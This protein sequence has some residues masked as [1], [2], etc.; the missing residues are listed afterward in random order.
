MTRRII[1]NIPVLLMMLL[2]SGCISV[3]QNQ[4]PE[5]AKQEN[6]KIQSWSQLD[7]APGVTTTI[8][9]DLI[10]SQELSNLVTEA[11]SANPGLQQTLLTLKMRQLELKQSQGAKQPTIEAGASVGKEQDSDTSYSGSLGISWEL[12]LWRKLSDES[13]AAAKDVA[14]QQA[15]YQAARDT[16][17]SEVMKAWLELIETEKSINIQKQRIAVLDQNTSLI[18]DRY[19]NGLGELSD[20]DSAR[21]SIAS[22]KATLAEYQQEQS[23]LQR[24]LATLLGQSTP[25]TIESAQDYPAVLLPLVDLPEQ[26]LQRRPDLKAAYLAIEAA[27]LRTSVAY[28]EML[29]SI[30]LQ[31][32]L[33]DVATSPSALLLQDSLW[34]LLGQLTAPL[35]QGGQLKTAAQI[36]ELETEQ[37]YQ[38]YRETLLTA[39][40]EVEDAIALE[41]SLL[42]RQQ[43]IEQALASARN[44]FTQYQHSYRNGLV[45]LLDLLTVQEQTYDLEEQLNTI[46]YNRL[47]NRIDLGL[48]LGLGVKS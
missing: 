28:K 29:P 26:T 2:L 16:L 23:S 15:T 46:I 48:A 35:Y 34:S 22:A 39:V 24:S 43:Y 9:G 10:R 40:N 42:Q 37:A 41:K 31:A 1:D 5:Q 33:E 44:T 11:L 20:L 14:E 32:A 7:T 8:L 17:A 47:A 38:A 45:E 36:A 13:Q 19:R 3:N 18:T 27:G 30:S 4:W 6:Q 21:T 12:D 25:V